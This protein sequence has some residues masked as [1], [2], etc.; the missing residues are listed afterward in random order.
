MILRKIFFNAR[1]IIPGIILPVLF[2]CA[3]YR[4]V[5]KHELRNHIKYLS[6]DSLKGR[7]T[8][9]AGDS[10]AAEYIRNEL[11]SDGLIPLVSDGSQKYTVTKRFLPGR[12][13]S[14]KIGKLSYIQ[15]KDF[16]P[17]LFSGD[18]SLSAEVVFAGY[19]FN[20]KS[21][22]LTWDDYSG[23]D[24]KGK[25]VLLLRSDPDKE[26]GGGAFIKYSADRDKSLVAKDM[27]AAGIL[28][29]SGNDDKSDE[30]AD[31]PETTGYSLG[32]PVFSIKRTLADDI[33][34]GR[35]ITLDSL[36]RKLNRNRKPA[37][38]GTSTV[39]SGRAE[40]VRETANTR[41]I[42]MILPGEDPVLKNQYIIIGAHFDHLGMGGPGSSSRKQDTIAVHHGADDNA[43]GVAMMLETAQKFA[44]TKGSHRRSIVCV[45]FS[46]E[47]E[48]LLGSKQ[49]VSDPHLD[50]SKVNAMVNFDMVG[51]LNE[52]KTLQISGVGT[53]AG[54]KNLVLS[55]ADTSE[56]KLA[57]SD[58]GY[59]PSDHSSFYGKDIPVLF[60]F[61]GAHEDY[62]T[63]EDT[64]DAINYDGMIKISDLIFDIVYQLVNSDS[65]LSFRE[66]GPKTPSATRMKGV[67]L[68]IMPDFAGVVKNGLRAD[69]VTPGRPAAVGGMKKGDIIISIEGKPVNNIEDYMFRMQQVK[70]GQTITVEVLR[71]DKKLGLLIQL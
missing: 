70:K 23:T 2:S 16:T 62:H 68:G 54:L 66:A 46:G 63:P 41:N 33:L 67:T 21:D 44:A 10:L 22:T 43:S 18:D 34:S 24:V 20:I 64:Y 61:T 39:V 4:G 50:L 7:L 37:T 8:G 52:D 27:G 49:F 51:R 14:L 26:K 3:S 60:F 32:I 71:N 53:A 30:K 45:A 65:T 1:L 15:G 29:V 11:A 42:A 35:R 25:W 69:F 12:R 17:M 47:E 59:G 58:E 38:F 13:N 28:L 55:K 40:L 6:S 9:S 57:L 36:E 31:P 19:G 48:G 56:L 5:T